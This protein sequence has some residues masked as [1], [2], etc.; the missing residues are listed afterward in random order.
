MCPLPHISED[1]SFFAHPVAIFRVQS[2][3]LG[4]ASREYS[5]CKYCF[6]PRLSL[7]PS[8]GAVMNIHAGNDADNCGTRA[9]LKE[10]H[11][12]GTISLSLSL[13]L[14]GC[15]FFACPRDGCPCARNSVVNSTTI[16]GLENMIA[17][18]PRHEGERNE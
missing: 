16:G 9:D 4:I 14:Y 18:T 7:S 11:T 10:L 15:A 8:G 2:I 3:L 6:R 5:Q 1:A 12:Q 13:F 17:I